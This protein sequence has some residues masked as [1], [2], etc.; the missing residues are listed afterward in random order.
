MNQCIEEGILADILSNQ[1][2][3]VLELVLSTF[4]K[5]LYEQEL[6][7]DAETR[8]ANNLLKELVKKKLDKNL[9]VE[10]IAQELE[11]DIHVI[12]D[13]IAQL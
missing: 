1:K 2:A 9:S 5:E 8:G 6:K 12:K 3:E 11:Q 4:D 10:V 7:Q 13:I